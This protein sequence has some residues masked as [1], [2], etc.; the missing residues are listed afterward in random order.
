MQN[1]LIWFLVQKLTFYSSTEETVPNV[2]PTQVKAQ[3]YHCWC[4]NTTWQCSY[5]TFDKLLLWIN[6]Q[7]NNWPSNQEGN[8]NP[9]SCKSSNIS[10]H[11]IICCPWKQSHLNQA[12]VLIDWLLLPGHWTIREHASSASCK[13]WIMPG[14]Q[15]FRVSIENQNK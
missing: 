10:P 5:T 2:C 11:I 15:F 14:K 3:W 12:L 1:A 8:C 7:C 4:Q 9:H 13:Q 6:T